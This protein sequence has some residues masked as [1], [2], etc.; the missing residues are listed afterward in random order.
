MPSPLQWGEVGAKLRRGVEAG[1][2]PPHHATHSAIILKCFVSEASKDDGRAREDVANVF[3][4]DPI[5][6]PYP[7]L[8]A[9]VD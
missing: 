8:G 3:L 4:S 2:E 6:P 1:S 5:G 7:V 9:A